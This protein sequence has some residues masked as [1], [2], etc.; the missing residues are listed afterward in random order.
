MK[1]AYLILC[2]TDLPLLHTLVCLLD[3][4]RN[5]IFIHIDKKAGY[6]GASLRTQNARLHILERRVDAKWGDYSLVKAELLLFEEAHAKGVYAYYHLLSGADL[7]LK[8]Q[9]YIHDWCNSHPGIEYIGFSGEETDK[10]TIWRTEHYFL[11]SCC[12]RSTNILIKAIRQAAIFFQGMFFLKRHVDMIVKKGP[13]WCSVTHDFVSYLLQN[14]EKIKRNFSHTF[15]PDELFIQTVCWNS[16]FRDRLYNIT[17]EFEGCMRY[18]RW[19]NGA[20]QDLSMATV[21]DALLS[22]CWFARKYSSQHSDVV[23]LVLEYLLPDM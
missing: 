1:H 16:P 18:I 15:C 2:H 8:G 17:K 7:P 20:L 11:F 10:E 19:S 14:K 5:G 21:N 6:S 9:D 4:E 22:N 3:D 13:Q 23:K 12:F